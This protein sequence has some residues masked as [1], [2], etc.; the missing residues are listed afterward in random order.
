MADTFK[1]IDDRLRTDLCSETQL[2]T[3][4]GTA[5]VVLLLGKVA[6]DEPHSSRKMVSSVFT[7]LLVAARLLNFTLF[8]VI[9]PISRIPVLKKKVIPLFTTHHSITWPANQGP[10]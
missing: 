2:E 7:S 4:I 9:I 10:A 1:R 6:I 5:Q 8:I 3:V